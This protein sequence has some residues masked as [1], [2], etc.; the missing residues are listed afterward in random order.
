MQVK[1][2]EAYF[3]AYE[4][5]LKGP[6]ATDRLY[7]WESQRVFQTHWDLQV[8]DL[9]AMYD[10]ALQNSQTRRLWNRQGYAPKDMMLRFAELQPDYFRQMFQ[11]LFDES[12]SEDGRIGRFVFYCD[13]LFESFLETHPKTK[14]QGHHHDDGYEIISLYL[15]FKYPAKYLPYRFDLFQTVLQRIGAVDP[16]LAHDT[17]RYFKVARTLN[18][19]IQRQATLLDLHQ[20]RLNPKVHY[21]EESLLLI[22]DF[23]CFVANYELKEE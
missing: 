14:I 7:I 23:C 18:K 12:K 3:R 9:Q 4:Q 22:Y 6:Q 16:P 11:E 1:K 8:T 20:K 17:P 10:S 13:Q 15:C 19:L 21:M 5:F 2:I